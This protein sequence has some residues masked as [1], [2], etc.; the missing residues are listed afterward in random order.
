MKVK[1]S[2]FISLF[3][4][5]TT[6]FSSPIGATQNADIKNGS[7]TIKLDNTQTNCSKENVSFGIKKV[8]DIK[9]GKYITNPFYQKLNINFN[10]IETTKD[11]E[12]IIQV[13][14]NKTKEPDTIVS[15]NENGI[16]YA[17]NLEIGLY[18]V[19]IIN[20][21]KY[22]NIQPFLVSIPTFDEIDKTT[23]YDI[24][25]SPKHESF[26]LLR[27]YKTN[28]ITNKTILNKNF[29]FNMYSN[30]LCD[31]FISKSNININEGYAEFTINYGTWYIKETIAPI[32]YQLS[33][34][35][36]KIDFND[37]GLFINN[38]FCQKEEQ[39][40]AIHFPNKP[41]FTNSKDTSDKSLII[42]YI[43]VAL[44][45]MFSIL[46]FRLRKNITHSKEH[47]F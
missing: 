36:I 20:I 10:Q 45:S 26:P 9:D 17:P 25:I 38:K 34:D 47:D 1:L 3:L 44:I 31:Q 22:D 18:L 29:E 23:I 8:A 11:L 4:L 24:E 7:I 28:S 15:T 35:I 2:L 30:K 5:C 12:T 16:A 6:I 37:K 13:L 39:F 42:L 46:Y 21:N 33:S 40:Y 32:G 14:T 43:I 19:Y 41:S 27:I